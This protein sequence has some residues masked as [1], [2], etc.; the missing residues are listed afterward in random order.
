MFK[1][2]V[3]P[4]IEVS[5]TYLQNIEKLFNE[6]W[7]IFINQLHFKNPLQEGIYYNK[8]AR[9][10]QIT[11]K[12]IPIQRGLVAANVQNEAIQIT[13]HK[14]LTKNTATPLHELFHVFQYNY[15]DINNMWFMEGLA[16]W[17]QN[18]I[19]KRKM[20]NETLP[21]N[22]DE[23]ATLLYK[24]HEAEYFWRKLFEFIEDEKL[25]VKLLFEELS[26]YNIE[27]K[28]DLKN[29]YIIFEAIL[30]ILSKTKYIY[31]KELEEFVYLLYNI[32]Q[33]N[34][35]PKENYD[36]AT[37][38][39]IGDLNI[40]TTDEI[41]QYSEIKYIQGTLNISNTNISI[42]DGFINLKEVTNI[43]IDKNNSLFKI[44]GFNSLQTINGFIKIINNKQLKSIKF[45]HNIQTVGSSFYLHNNSLENLQ[46]LEQLH[47]VGAS[48]SL[49]NNK[50]QNLKELK[51][52]TTINGL[53]AISFNQLKTL[54][55]IENLK[56]ISTTKWG[57]KKF[58]IKLYNN[59]H[60][61][62]IQALSN[63][64][65]K[66][67]NLIIIIDNNQNFTSIPDANSNF[68]N[69][70]IKVFDKNGNL[71]LRNKVTK[72]KDWSLFEELV[73]C[74][75][76]NNC[77]ICRNK[78]YGYSWRKKF[79]D[80]ITTPP[81]GIDF[82]CPYN[83]PW[84]WYGYISKTEKIIKKERPTI[85]EQLLFAQNHQDD[86]SFNGDTIDVVYPYFSPE[87]DSSDELRYSLRSL[88]NIYEKVNVWI[89]G[90]KP[91][92][93]NT[94][95]VNYI[96][97]TK[98]EDNIW[99]DESRYIDSRAKVYLATKNKKIGSHFIFMNDDLYI[100]YPIT[101]TFMGIPR[102]YH[103]YT[104][105]LS[106]FR[107]TVEYHKTQLRGFKALE[108]KG[109][110][111]KEYSLHWPYVH[112]T[113]SFINMYEEFQMDKIPYNHES[114]YFNKFS[115]AHIP[116]Q[117]ELLRIN[118]I[119][120]DEILLEDI[121]QNVFILNNKMKSFRK[122]KN[123]LHTLFPNPSIYERDR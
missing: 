65:E 67:N 29:N 59:T 35:A 30:Q 70:N 7:D 91:D 102:Y 81:G 52:L 112:K 98:Q 32:L 107:V 22:K 79:Y 93:L 117:G 120:N 101:T 116:Y 10:I 23:L 106:K 38:T 109:L 103:D 24:K 88:Q 84:S 44:S 4:N 56:S 119:I 12:D 6:A 8:G 58:A 13:L 49:S 47:S 17:S 95:T 80:N 94:N 83:K 76:N 69:N 48:L 114:I 37:D 66:N 62:D 33:Q 78:K 51:N 21:Q 42:I 64:I 105:D 75:T 73:M 53:L 41:K 63:I 16:R 87:Q 31:S 104:G 28:K 25:F 121:P 85:K 36:I 11:I 40:T 123:L 72:T 122:I 60:L 20:Q 115:K 3:A 34:T 74:S 27:N 15:S 5:K 14:G 26:K 111:L 71:L 77:E 89:V 46:G 90:D 97:H 1:F 18:L 55:G 54:N 43:L 100:L 68:A 57:D 9:Y 2:I 61:K 118:K 96:P 86:D 110:P 82:E 45:L 99:G 19:Q 92:W 113:S 39:Y 50:L 108:Q